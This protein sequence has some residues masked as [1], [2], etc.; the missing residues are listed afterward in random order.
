[1]ALLGF[2]DIFQVIGCTIKE[3]RKVMMP[4]AFW[5]YQA[6]GGSHDGLTVRLP[7][8]IK[9]GTTLPIQMR[10]PGPE[11]DLRPDPEGRTELYQLEPDGKLYFLDIYMKDGKRI[12]PPGVREPSRIIQNV[13]YYD[14]RFIGGSHD[15]NNMS[16][17]HDFED[18]F[19]MAIDM[20]GENGP[21]PG[22]K[23]E[24]YK[25]G[26]DR[27][28]H[29]QNVVKKDGKQFPPPKQS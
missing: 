2:R 15:G 18:N 6:L 3:E 21:L 1:L 4:K 29:Y 12:T 20:R 17:P 26:S 19:C 16:L 9:P 10:A 28:F 14:Y 23:Q 11:T 5:D 7:E 27:R 25:L 8:E 13:K 22:G 24:V